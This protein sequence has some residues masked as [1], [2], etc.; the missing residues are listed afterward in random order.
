MATLFDDDITAAGNSADT[1]TDWFDVTGVATVTV[2]IVGVN[3]QQPDIWVEWTDDMQ[4]AEPEPQDVLNQQIPI[5][6]H[7]H[8]RAEGLSPAGTYLRLKATAYESTAIFHAII[9]TN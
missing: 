3:W 4:G 8:L 7:Y 1:F 2:D 9:T 6:S 5:G